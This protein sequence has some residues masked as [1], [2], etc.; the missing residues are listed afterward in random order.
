MHMYD[1]CCLPGCDM[2][3]SSANILRCQRIL[4][5]PLRWLNASEMSA[6]HDVTR[7]CIMIQVLQCKPTNAH[8][9]LISHCNVSI[10][11]N[12]YM[13]RPSLAN[14]HAVDSCIKVVK[15]FCHLRYIVL[16]YVH[17]C[18]NCGKGYVHSNWLLQLLCTYTSLTARVSLSIIHTLM[19]I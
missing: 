15:T 5:S 2:V 8:T 7:P 17:Q 6:L 3:W 18:M 4:Q 12:C 13:F 19:K 11:T 10:F 9:S 1:D 16:S 14:H